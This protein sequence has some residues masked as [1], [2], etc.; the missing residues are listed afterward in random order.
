MLMTFELT[1]I[2]GDG[3]EISLTLEK[4]M[5]VFVELLWRS[6]V[7]VVQVHVTSSLPSASAG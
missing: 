5:S 7:D 2:D 4:H 1:Y 3:D 6:R